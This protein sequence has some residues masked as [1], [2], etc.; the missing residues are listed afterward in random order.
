MLAVGVPAASAAPSSDARGYVDS[1]ARCATADAT[2]LFGST[3]ASRV[4][5]CSV[6]GGKYE[7][8]GVRLRDGAKLIVPATRNDDG[9][10]RVENAGIEYL[11]TSK[12]LVL[13]VGEKV[14]RE[15][16]MV[17]FHRP[18]APA[19]AAASPTPTTPLPPP[20]A[21]EVGGS[22]VRR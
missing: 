4:A 12:S 20:L 18:G 17:D 19:P 21:A 3:D 9:A 8:R 16:A 5:I 22:G 15:E 6:S 14:I 2:V 13:S 7:Y 1:T 10:F 11:V